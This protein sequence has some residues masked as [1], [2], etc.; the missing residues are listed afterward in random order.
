MGFVKEPAPAKAGHV[1]VPDQGGRQLSVLTPRFAERQALG[2]LSL[3]VLAQMLDRQ[4]GHDS[5][6]GGACL[7]ST[8][9]SLP[10]ARCK[11]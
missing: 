1:D 8:I 9:R 5:P 2:V 6:P 7:G 4:P 3:A 10:L 11:A